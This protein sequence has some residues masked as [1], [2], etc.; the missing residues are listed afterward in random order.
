MRLTV[1][2]ITQEEAE[3]AGWG[4]QRWLIVDADNPSEV[5]YYRGMLGIPE[6]ADY[7]IGAIGE[8]RRWERARGYRV[9]LSPEMQAF[10]AAKHG[11]EA[12]LKLLKKCRLVDE[13]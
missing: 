12:A 4:N 6:G 5:L 10:E 7:L 2:H 3:V 9:V 11:L 8:A 13:V 1:R